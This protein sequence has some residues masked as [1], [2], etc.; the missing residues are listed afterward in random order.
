LDEALA[1]ARKTLDAERE[2]AAGQLADANLAAEELSRKVNDLS[3]QAQTLAQ[4]L[5]AE[6]ARVCP[7]CE[8]CPPPKECP[9]IGTSTSASTEAS[10][11]WPLLLA[12]G[13]GYIV[14]KNLGK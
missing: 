12:L 2:R 1:D 3:A 4:E 11:P 8:V 5:E 9:E 7:T 6:R 14:G 10:S 13:G